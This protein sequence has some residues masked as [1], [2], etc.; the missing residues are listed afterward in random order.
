MVASTDASQCVFSI[1][2]CGQMD[3]KCVVF[4]LDNQNAKMISGLIVLP[5]LHTAYVYLHYG[6][7]TEN[8]LKTKKH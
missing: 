1:A 2:D 5:I 3:L 4:R 6:D 8:R 7:K